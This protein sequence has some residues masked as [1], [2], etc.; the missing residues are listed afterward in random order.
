[1]A[2]SELDKVARFI[3]STEQPLV[4]VIEP[5]AT[6]VTVPPGSNFSVHYPAPA[7]RDDTSSTEVYADQITFW[8]EG[9][10]FEVEVDG[11]L[12]PT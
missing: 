8:C 6:E 7:S 1:M 10:T 2:G 9:D 4:L 5:W 11:K 12:V 3:N